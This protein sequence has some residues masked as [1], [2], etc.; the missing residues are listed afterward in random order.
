M[1][2]SALDVVNQKSKNRPETIWSMGNKISGGFGFWGSYELL[3]NANPKEMVKAW[4]DG[5][6]ELGF[7]DISI[8]FY[9]DWSAGRHIADQIDEDTTYQ[10]FKKV[11]KDQSDKG[12]TEKKILDGY[13][14]EQIETVQYMLR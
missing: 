12:L 2:I 11:V 13:T 4:V 1:K 6:R 3:H 10:Q 7:S 9:G 14:K 5:L 8:V